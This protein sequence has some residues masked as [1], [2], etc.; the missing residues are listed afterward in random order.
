MNNKTSRWKFGVGQDIY[1]ISKYYPAN[2]LLITVPSQ[3][4]NLA[5]TTLTKWSKLI[6][7][8]ILGQ[9]DIT[10]L[11]EETTALKKIQH[12]LWFPTENAEPQANH[13]GQTHLTERKPTK[14]R[15]PYSW[16]RSKSRETE[17]GWGTV[18][19]E[20]ELSVVTS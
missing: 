17:K 3:W 2:Y 10:Y 12:P 11:W 8:T 6:N 14:I 19:D 5:D 15:G 20:R 9:T 1:Q 4:R 7:V 18:P 13:E 16:T